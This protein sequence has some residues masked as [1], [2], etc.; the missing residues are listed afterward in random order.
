V[1]T[2]TGTYLLMIINKGKYPWLITI[3]N[4]AYLTWG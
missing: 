1:A 3:F 4:L 2:S